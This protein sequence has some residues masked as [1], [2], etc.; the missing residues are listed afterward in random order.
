M[1]RYTNLEPNHAIILEPGFIIVLCPFIN[2]DTG[3]P[4]ETS[5]S[6][7]AEPDEIN[8]L[9]C[10]YLNGKLYHA[11]PPVHSDE[12]PGTPPPIQG[13]QHPIAHVSDYQPCRVPLRRIQWCNISLVTHEGCVPSLMRID[14]KW[15]AADGPRRY[16]VR[17]GDT[18]SYVCRHIAGSS[19]WSK[20]SWGCAVDT[21]WNTNGY[22]ASHHDYP[23]WFVD[24]WISEGWGW[25]GNWH[26]SKDWMHTSRFPNEGGNGLLYDGDGEEDDL[27]YTKDQLKAIFKEVIEEELAKK[28]KGSFKNLY[29]WLTYKA[30]DGSYR[31]SGD[32]LVKAVGADPTKAP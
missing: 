8:C 2:P 22:N 17:Q 28:E 31:Q 1:A 4:F 21:N 5:W 10:E 26:S 20:H 14:R 3:H 25:G 19:N 18:A 15:R 27:P 32:D 29:L 9:F 12:K 7:D 30:K 11:G 23:Q 6:N 13:G 24:I 16:P